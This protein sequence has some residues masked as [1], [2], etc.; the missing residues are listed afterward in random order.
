MEEK[1]NTYGKKPVIKFRF[2]NFWRTIRCYNKRDW[3][4][5]T[6]RNRSIV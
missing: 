5:G 3:F 2:D 1:W 4:H 6:R